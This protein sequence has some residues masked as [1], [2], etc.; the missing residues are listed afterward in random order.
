MPKLS[1][2]LDPLFLVLAFGIGWLNSSTPLE[3]LLWAIVIFI[4]ILV[5]ELGHALTAIA[6]GHTAEITF[7]PLGGL[8]ARTGPKLNSLREFLI[9]LNG[10]LAGF[11]LYFLC[12]FLLQAGEFT[13][14]SSFGYM[15]LI[16]TY[17]N[18]VWT[19][20]NLFPVLPLD[21][22][23]LVMI[24]MEKIFGIKGG[25]IAYGIS[26]ITAALFGL[27]FFVMQQLFAGAIFSLFAFESYR[28]F[29]QGKHITAM[30]E[31][32]DVKDLLKKGISRYHQGD[33]EEADAIFKEVRETAKAGLLYLQA[34]ILLSESL[35]MQQDFKQAYTLLKPEEKKLDIEGLELLQ[36]LAFKA[37]DFKIAAKL[38]S[39]VFQ[40]RPNPDTAFIN[41]LSLA[42]LKEVTPAVGWFETAIREGLENPKL[43]SRHLSFDPIRETEAFKNLTKRHLG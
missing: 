22:G 8:T 11:A 6:F 5:H 35:E 42:Q 2:K 34:T 12:R 20:L 7:M 24:V 41:A 26:F 37:N 14:T 25:R 33:A 43:S 9:V 28:G 18:L 10:P 21:G 38:G 19:I 29:M 16:G 4:S 32:E 1:F 39:E 15:L 3:I 17:I 40:E 13:S 30:D 27:L 23:K 36:R 31:D